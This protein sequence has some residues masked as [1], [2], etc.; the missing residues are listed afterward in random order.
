MGRNLDVLKA[1]ITATWANPPSSIVEAN[2]KYLS[3]DYKNLDKDGNVVMDKEAYIGMGKL[4]ASAFKDMKAVYG[5]IR[6]EGDSVIVPFHFEGTHTGDLDLSA[7]GMGVIPASGKRIVWPED[8]VVFK[9]RGDKIVSN[10]PYGDS[11][12][13]EA[14]LAELGVKMPT[15]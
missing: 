12:G 14:F 1:Y 5:N 6:E 7:M 15:A 2:E 10:S 13:I 3:D 4:L 8:T 9:F 11:A